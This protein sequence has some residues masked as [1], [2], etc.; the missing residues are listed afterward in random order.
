M[1]SV[2]CSQST[3]GCLTLRKK[4]WSLKVLI[5]TYVYV[6]KS[7]IIS[8]TKLP[9]LHPLDIRFSFLIHTVYK[10]QVFRKLRTWAQAQELE[11]TKK[12]NLTSLENYFLLKKYCS[13]L[14]IKLFFSYT[15]R[16][17]RKYIRNF[18]KNVEFAHG[19]CRLCIVVKVFWSV[20]ECRRTATEWK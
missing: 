1:S 10:L 14:F 16:F 8:I 4:V 12:D 18:R 15:S 6:N 7:A 13:F 11:A 17:R 2:P 9:S 19:K 20:K 5:G 3:S